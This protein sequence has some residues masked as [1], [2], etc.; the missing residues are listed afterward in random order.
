MT[1]AIEKAIERLCLYG[2]TQGSEN[3]RAETARIVQDARSECSLIRDWVD[4]ASRLLV[5]G[6]GALYLPHR[7]HR[8]ICKIWVRSTPG[9]LPTAPLGG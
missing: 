9:P 1:Q 5:L 3:L 7:S 2:F 4:T 8:P 6:G